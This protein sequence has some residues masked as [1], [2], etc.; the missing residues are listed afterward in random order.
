MSRQL[1]VKI[2]APLAVS[3]SIVAAAF[4]MSSAP[5][6]VT[7]GTAASALAAAALPISQGVVPSLAPMLK[8]VM[9]AVVNIS[10]TAKA[11]QRVQNP[12][13][14]DPF[15]RRFFGAPDQQEDPR[16]QQQPE[17]R[18]A[19]SIGSGVIVDAVK[20]YIIT[21]NHVVEQADTIKVRLSDNREFDAKLIGKDPETDVA[22]LQIKADN[23][24]A[25]PLS[26]SSKAEVGDFVVAIGSPFGL[27]QTVTSG[28]ISG[29]SRQTGISEGGYEDFIQTDASINPG[30]SG[31]ALINLQGQLVGI[32]SNIYS[33]SGGN[34]GLGFAIPVNLAKSVMDQLIS[35]GSVQRGRIGVMGQDLDPQLSKAMGLDRS[36]GAVITK[37][38]P[39]SPAANAGLKTGDIILAANGHEIENFAQLRN[40]V[41]LMRVGDKVEMKILRDN[42]PQTVTVVIGK[43]TEQTAAASELSPLLAGASFAPI[44]ESVKQSTE[45]VRGVLL[46]ALEPRSP[47]ARTGLRPGDIVD[48]VN[49]QPVDSME[50]FQK[51]AGPKATQLLLHVRRGNGALFILLQ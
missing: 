45:D 3:A 18:E 16:G 37:I 12:L 50:T 23:I 13:L 28:I 35:H 5:V 51:L 31:G 33:P 42:K 15:F 27:R 26:D 2:V 6:A 20:G 4:M 46:K 14:Q 47:A 34:I 22:V 9:P 8:Q 25:V 10:V 41:G 38:V 36:N 17:E 40:L 29:L 30:N 1:L 19:Q 21:N 48:A 24:K 43:S 7:A 39:K 32:P 44:D 49:R 11:E